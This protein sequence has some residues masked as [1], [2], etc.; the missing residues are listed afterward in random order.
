MKFIDYVMMFIG[1][2]APVVWELIKVKNPD[3]PL[4]LQPFVDLVMY[5]FA[6][7]FGIKAMKY[8]IVN[9]LEKQGKTYESL[10]SE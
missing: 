7:L 8:F 6:S 1:V 5:I 10:V 9:K 2:L 3:F 4:D